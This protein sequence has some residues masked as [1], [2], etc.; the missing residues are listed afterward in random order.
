MH[1]ACVRQRALQAQ[2]GGQPGAGVEQR[3]PL[4]RVARRVHAFVVG[5]EAPEQRR[6]AG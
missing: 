3:R 5:R 4:P 2:L 1:S 6:A